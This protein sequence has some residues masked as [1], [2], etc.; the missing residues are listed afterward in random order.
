MRTPLWE[1]LLRV[2]DKASIWDD[3]RSKIATEDYLEPAILTDRHKLIHRRARFINKKY[4]VFQKTSGLTLKF[5]E[6]EMYDLK[7]DPLEQSNQA[8]VSQE[9]GLLK[10]KLD[11]FEKR[12]LD[13]KNIF[14]KAKTRIQDYQ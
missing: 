11:T 10:Q 1:S 14:Q 12:I 13:K 8:F 5:P 2:R 9:F 6:Y 4:S 7:N 3:F